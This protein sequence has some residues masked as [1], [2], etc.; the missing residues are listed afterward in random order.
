L[1]VNPEDDNDT[2][3]KFVKIT[4][5][6]ERESF[7]L[8][9]VDLNISK[10]IS[11]PFLDFVLDSVWLRHSYQELTFRGNMVFP[12][13]P[14]H[15]EQL[16]SIEREL[17][18]VLGPSQADYFD[19]VDEKEA[20]IEVAQRAQQIFDTIAYI[21]NQ[22]PKSTATGKEA[23]QFLHSYAKLGR[24]LRVVAEPS[25]ALEVLNKELLNVKIPYL[26]DKYKASYLQFNKVISQEKTFWT[27]H[28]YD[29]AVES[30]N[31]YEDALSLLE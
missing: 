27:Q 6:L 25:E 5:S 15:L 23:M 4:P 19:K 29:D 16:E 14:Y 21:E 17:D 22:Y 7:G 11:L 1:V 3:N 20:A 2:V 12:L 30:A 10:R 9:K 26:I 18:I 8:P 13:T 24:V 31:L 28:L